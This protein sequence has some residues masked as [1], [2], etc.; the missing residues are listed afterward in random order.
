[1]ERRNATA[2][3]LQD[4]TCSATLEFDG[5]CQQAALRSSTAALITG[6][7]R[8]DIDHDFDLPG[9]TKNNAWRL[10]NIQK[11]WPGLKYITPGY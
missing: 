1:V 8:E 7:S 4:L 5:G 6:I 2:Q 11:R 3:R 9:Y 10:V